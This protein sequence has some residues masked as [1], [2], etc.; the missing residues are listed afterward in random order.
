[1]KSKSES[2]LKNLRGILGAN[3]GTIEGFVI[4]KKGVVYMKKI[5]PKKS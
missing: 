3:S 1:M 4:T 5:K 2:K